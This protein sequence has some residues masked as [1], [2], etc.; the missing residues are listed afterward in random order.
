M[1]LNSH[2][3]AFFVGMQGNELEGAY[4][5]QFGGAVVGGIRDGGLDILTG[6]SR[7]PYVQV[8]SSLRGLQTFLA[9]SLRFKRFIPICLGEPGRREEMVT[10]LLR[11]GVWVGSDIPDREKIKNAVSQVRYLCTA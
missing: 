2:S 11:Y 7:V 4:A 6:D 8:K 10:H 9:D 3:K 5:K 1:N